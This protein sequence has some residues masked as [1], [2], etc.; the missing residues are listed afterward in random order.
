MQA[1]GRCLVCGAP[2]V[3]VMLDLGRHPVST[4]FLAAEDPDAPALPLELAIC[5]RC[6]S[7]QLSR[8]FP[9]DL[10]AP[11]YG[12]MTYR[13]PEDHLDDVVHGV[14][15]DAEPGRGALIV[16]VSSKDES[17]LHRFAR[18]GFG[19]TW[20][21]DVHIDLGATRTH[22][23]VETVQ[24]L[25]TPDK[26]AS[27]AERHGAADIVI[28]RHIV[29]HA[30][31]PIAFL[32]ALAGLLSAG[33]RLVVEVPDCAKNLERQDY[34]MIWE[35][36]CLYFTSE[37]LLRTL[38]LAGFDPVSVTVHPYPFE[39]VIVAVARKSP[40]P[41]DVPAPQ[42]E[43]DLALR[44]AATFADAF[45]TWTARYRRVLE[46][47]A[48]RGQLSLYGA[49]HLTA[50]FVNF[51]GLAD[52]FAFVV[53]DTPEKQG[54]SLANA[55]LPIVPRSALV[56]DGVGTCLMGLSPT[57]EEKVIANNRAY[58]ESGGRFYSLLVD[59][60]RTIRHETG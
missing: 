37:T 34:T 48:G 6:V 31:R 57:T 47:E 14:I 58:V 5:R 44:R 28:A 51:H 9:D 10:L 15:A 18:R 13:E 39:D 1:T 17:T 43:R 33:G 42:P 7:V 19:R 52:L 16:G 25:L 30:A 59:S 35:E 12:W 38:R 26:A 4:H 60:R 36:H 27:L 20:C 3:D 45:E 54:L 55:R 46:R 11:R 8:P 22:A 21:P 24:A 23:G 32:E 41:T 50:A 2:D 56:D 49:G 53:D 29:E 40:V